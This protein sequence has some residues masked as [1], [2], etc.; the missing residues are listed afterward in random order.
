MYIEMISKEIF[1]F[2]N[3]HSKGSLKFGFGFV[4]NQLTVT[5]IFMWCKALNIDF[6]FSYFNY[7]YILLN[8]CIECFL[9]FFTFISYFPYKYNIKGWVN[10]HYN[11]AI[12]M[13]VKT[14]NFL[15]TFCLLTIFPL[16]FKGTIDASL[17]S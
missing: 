8:K 15:H 3:W 7:K 14:W 10:R 5:L 11:V 17:V 13:L 16:T 6:L 2:D 4:W 1:V 9:Y 12:E